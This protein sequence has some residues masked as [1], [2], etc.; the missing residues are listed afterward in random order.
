[1][2]KET[3]G[4]RTGEHV[5]LLA[6]RLPVGHVKHLQRNMGHLS[7][8]RKQ[9]D[10]MGG[11]MKS[12]TRRTL[13]IRRRWHTDPRGKRQE[14]QHWQ[15][16]RIRTLCSASGDK[17]TGTHNEEELTALLLRLAA[18]AVVACTGGE[19]GTTRQVSH[20]ARTPRHRLVATGART[21]CAVIAVNIATSSTAFCGEGGGGYNPA[22]ARRRTRL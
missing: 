8:Q 6:H 20:N 3:T 12:T 17:S 4:E 2:Q 7:N 5:P 11:P 18:H 14:Q 9:N 21:R 16:R 22:L 19:L 13:T 1:M 10:A 15:G